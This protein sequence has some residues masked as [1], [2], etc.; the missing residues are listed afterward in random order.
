[1]ETVRGVKQAYSI[2]LSTPKRT[3]KGCVGCGK[4]YSLS[5]SLSTLQRRVMLATTHKLPQLCLVIDEHHL[6]IRQNV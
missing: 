5:K 4:H 1:M 2:Q 3:C 6:P